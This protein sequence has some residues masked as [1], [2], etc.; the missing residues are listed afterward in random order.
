MGH[1]NDSLI[2]GVMFCRDHEFDILVLL[3]ISFAYFRFL[4]VCF[5]RCLSGLHRYLCKIIQFGVWLYRKSNLSITEQRLSMVI[6]VLDS[7]YYLH[8]TAQTLHKVDIIIFIL[9]DMDPIT[10]YKASK[11]QR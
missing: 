7:I 4:S 2:S 1:E 10:S 9:T 6:Y 3:I 5:F 8:M 11:W